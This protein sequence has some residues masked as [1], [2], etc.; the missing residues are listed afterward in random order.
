MYVILVVNSQSMNGLT[1]GSSAAEEVGSEGVTE[2][3]ERQVP[4]AAEHRAAVLVAAR[5]VP[6]PYPVTV[7]RAERGIVASAAALL[8][9]VRAACFFLFV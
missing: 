3:W 2:A 7:R 6:W 8:V 1:D 9:V 5:A 4:E